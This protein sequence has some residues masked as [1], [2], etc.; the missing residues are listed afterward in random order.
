VADPAVITRQQEMPVNSSYT[1]C[2]QL[3]PEGRCP[4]AVE[5]RAREGELPHSHGY[6]GYPP[7]GGLGLSE[8][9]NGRESGQG[10]ERR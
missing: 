8:S 6:R 2:I 10:Q 1:S 5:W 4:E 7:I 9:K 3:N